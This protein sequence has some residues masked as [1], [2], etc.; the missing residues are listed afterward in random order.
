MAK[1][2]RM[3]FCLIF[4]IAVFMLSGCALP[5][6]ERVYWAA[7]ETF[8]E[9]EVWVPLVGSAVFLIGDADETASEW[10]VDETPIFSSDPDK[11]DEISDWLRA[12]LIAGAGVTMITAS[13]TLDGVSRKDHI[14][15]ELATYGSTWAVTEGLKRTVHRER[16]DQEDNKSFPS[17]HA[18]ISFS[19]ASIISYNLDLHSMNPNAR[20]AMKI[21]AYSVA[22]LTAWA[23]VEA[24]KHYPSDVLAGVAIGNFITRFINNV[25]LHDKKYEQHGIRFLP[26]PGGAVISYMYR[27]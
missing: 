11:T 10:A 7:K 2:P 19:M 18:S 24:N 14:I 6:K 15:T 4:G 27:Y 17:G 1:Y 13:P 16:P 12:S 26:A 3:N 23:R 22:G 8:K 20:K 5:T 21:G 25:Y 9:P